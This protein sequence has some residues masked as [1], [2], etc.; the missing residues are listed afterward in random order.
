MRSVTRAE[1]RAE[2]LVALN[3]EAHQLALDG[4]IH[5]TVQNR[6]FLQILLVDGFDHEAAPGLAQNAEL[7]DLLA[8]EPLDRRC[9]EA[10]FL[11][12][13][14]LVDGLAQAGQN[15]IAHAD[16]RAFISPGDVQEDAGRR[17]IL[18]VPMQRRGDQIAVSVLAANHDHANLRQRLL[19]HPPP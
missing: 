7:A 15:V 5:L 1:G 17:A 18:L 9:D 12:A 10:E 3:L 6:Q 19:A 4:A 2:L 11:L 8:R 13:V 14:R 16:G